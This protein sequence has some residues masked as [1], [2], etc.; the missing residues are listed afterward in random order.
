MFR[1]VLKMNKLFLK[2][3]IKAFQDSRFQIWKSARLVTDSKDTLDDGLHLSAVTLKHHV[4][5]KK[6]CSSTN[7]NLLYSN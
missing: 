1:D 6:I 5:V 7:C 2:F 4:Q 3:L